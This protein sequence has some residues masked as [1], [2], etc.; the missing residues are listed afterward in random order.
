MSVL[1]ET[2]VVYLICDPATDLFKIGMTRSTTSRR[3][4]Q[5]QT[6]NGTELIWRDSYE[7]KY[8]QKVETVLHRK[9]KHKK[10][11]GEWFRLDVDDIIHF[12]DICAQIEKNII[13]IL[14]NNENFWE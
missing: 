13:S 3:L 9:Y 1:G 14:E 4:K 5:L 7:T 6:G 2:G 10:E 8:P 11:I 12:K